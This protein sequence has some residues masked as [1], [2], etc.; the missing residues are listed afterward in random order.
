MKSKF[1][2]KRT[3]NADERSERCSDANFAVFSSTLLLS[4]SR[5]IKAFIHK[6]IKEICRFTILNR[7]NL[8]NLI[9]KFIVTIKTKNFGK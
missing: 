8:I 7:S 1:N 3:S 2:S 6:D 9:N 4:S 5:N